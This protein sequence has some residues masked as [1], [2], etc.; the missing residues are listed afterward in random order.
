MIKKIILISM[1]CSLLIDCGKKADPEYKA[2][3]NYIL[4]NKV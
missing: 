4:I 3:K 2:Y 1:V